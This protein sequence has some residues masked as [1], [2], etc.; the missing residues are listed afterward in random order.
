MNAIQGYQIKK[1]GA[2]RGIPRIWLEGVHPGK[3]GFLPGVRFNAS[4][5]KARSLLTLEIMEDGLRIVSGKKKGDHQ[6]PIIDLNSKELLSIFDGIESV[7]VLVQDGKISILPVA[8]E[9]RAK[10]RLEIIKAKIDAGLPIAT[11]A[12]SAGI[13]VLDHAIHAGLSQAGINSTLVLSNEIREDCQ[14]QAV[15]YND[16]YTASTVLLNG[17]LQEIAFDQYVMNHLPQVDFLIA[18]LPCSGASSAGA[19]KLGLAMPENHPAV[20]HLIVAFLAV[21]GKLNPAIIAF[22]NVV[23]YQKS[24]SMAIMRTQLED[25]GYIIHETHLDA[26]DW[27][28]LEHRKRMCMIATTK[29][30]PEFSFDAIEKPVKIVRHLGEIMDDISLDD[31][32]W[33]PMQY[34]KDKQVRDI[35]EKKGFSMNLVDKNSTKVLTLNK[36]LAKR[37]STGTFFIHPI[38]ANLQRLPTCNEHARCKNIP[39]ILITGVSQTFGHEGLG[40]SICYDPFVA[41][42]KLIGNMLINLKEKLSDVFQSDYVQMPLAA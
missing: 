33:S 2:N 14:N 20:G 36:T 27:N 23:N 7:R 17:P 26:E 38:D 10:E 31:P 34:L 8:S 12:L 5:N 21:I 42:G 4:V 32:S 22:E 6:I 37:Q 30:M 39:E 13:G 19:T 41:T 1:I 35:A 29:G 25:L 3:G 15:A 24:A 11:G 16:A 18:G 40:Q 28:A 9:Q